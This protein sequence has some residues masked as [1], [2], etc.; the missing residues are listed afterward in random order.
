VCCVL[1]IKVIVQFAITINCNVCPHIRVLNTLIRES[2][3]RRHRNTLFPEHVRHL[4]SINYGYFRVKVRVRVNFRVTV[5]GNS[6]RCVLKFN[7]V[8]RY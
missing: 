1:L 5:L 3:A 8:L 4:Y 6:D 2:Y 7:S